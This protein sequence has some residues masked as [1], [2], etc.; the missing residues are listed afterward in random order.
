MFGDWA[1]EVDLRHTQN[2][3]CGSQKK[4]AEGRDSVGQSLGRVPQV[5]SVVGVVFVLMSGFHG[6]LLSSEED[7]FQQN[8]QKEDVGPVAD[9]G[10]KVV[11]VLGQLVSSSHGTSKVDT[12]TDERPEPPGTLMTARPQVWMD[13]AKE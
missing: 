9:H 7:L 8:E 13:S 4:G 2:G 5:P 12:A 11:E 10:Q 1:L 3:S 6:Q